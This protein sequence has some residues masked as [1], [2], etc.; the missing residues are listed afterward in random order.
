MSKG[1][2]SI[3]VLAALVGVGAWALVRFWGA[4]GPVAIPP[5]GYIAFGL[6]VLTLALAIGGMVWLAFYSERKGYDD[7]DRKDS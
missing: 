5:G 3:V 4:M 7:T 6:G 1:L 2:I